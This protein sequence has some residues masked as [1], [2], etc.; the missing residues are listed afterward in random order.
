MLDERSPVPL[1]YQLQEIVRARIE[2]GQWK[3]GQ[4]LPPEAELCAEFALS[5]GTVR[6]ALADLVREGLLH[7]R[8]GKGSFVAQPKIAQD[9][10][11][12][13]GFTA[14][15]N[16]MAG[17]ELGTRL[18]S[19]NIV[20]ANRSLAERL[21][22]AEGTELVEIR[23]VKLAEDQPFFLG[24]TYLPRATFPGLEQLDHSGSLFHLLQER[25]G[26]RVSKVKGWFEPVLIND[27][28]ASALGVDKG[29]PAMMFE[30]I[31]YGIDSRP[32]MI[33]KHIIRGDMCRL[34]FQIG[35]NGVN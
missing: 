4:Q 20:P 15:A 3:P 24:T 7:R 21:E 10:M 28:E 6:Q 8:R 14:F 13:A 22:L 27:Y 25:Y 26:L 19:V 32:V 9:L 18:I 29:S 16:Q 31:R 35:G 17:T 23:K 2:S 11:S 12:L 1:Y 34:T 30:R 33:S 5:R